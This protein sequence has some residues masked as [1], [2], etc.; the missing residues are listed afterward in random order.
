MMDLAK[1]KAFAD[2]ILSVVKMMI[3]VCDQVDNIVGKRKNAGY[4]QLV[5]SI[6]SFSLTYL[7]GLFCKGCDNQVLLLVKVWNVFSLEKLTVYYWKKM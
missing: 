4:Q 1:L 5:T 2:N 7:K 6:F 3:S